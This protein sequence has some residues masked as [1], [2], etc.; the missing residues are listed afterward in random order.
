MAI[1]VLQRKS[2]K[3]YRVH[4]MR[5]GKRISK[6]FDR[7]KEAEKFNAQLIANDDL[8]N[9]LTQHVTAVLSLQDACS[10]Y[11]AQHSGKDVSIAQR[12][13]W[14]CQQYGDKPTGQITKRHVK[15]SL[16]QLKNIGRA[17]ATINR[18]KAALSAIYTYLADEYD[19]QH[20]PARE[21]KQL[22]EDNARTRFLSDL[23]LNR[24]LTVSRASNWDR[25]YLLVLMAVTTG[26]R[27]TELLTLR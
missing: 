9:L 5:N 20:N 15:D 23:E 12:L 1:Q 25:L 10:D 19:I 21:V 6:V 16:K 18:Y 27:R 13:A 7:K 22:K 8:S 17:P 2:G 26:A 3:R 4:M 14:W 24:L 11:L